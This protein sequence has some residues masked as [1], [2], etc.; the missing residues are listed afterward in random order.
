MSLIT[1]NSMKITLETAFS[2]PCKLPYPN[3]YLHLHFRLSHYTED[4]VNQYSKPVTSK[5]KDFK[6]IW[7]INRSGYSPVLKKNFLMIFQ[8]L[9][10]SLREI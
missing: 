6:V 10:G 4:K 3:L 5:T 9:L 2:T 8:V 1:W 7:H